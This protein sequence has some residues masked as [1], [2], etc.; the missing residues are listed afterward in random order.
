MSR[1]YPNLLTQEGICGNEE[2]PD[3]THNVTLPFTRM[4]NGAADY[5][6]CY[7]DRRLKN[8]H[9]HQL[10]AS[11]IFYS[12]LQTILWYDTPDSY[13]GEPEIKWF[14]DLESVFDDTRV[15]D[16]Y[17]GKGITMARRRGDTWW[18]A[19]MANNDGGA[20]EIPLSFLNNQKKYQAEIYTDGDGTTGTRTNVKITRQR[21]TGKDTLRFMIP[22]RGGVA[23]R[24]IPD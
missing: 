21:V 17:P 5:T 4:L 6:I 9:A 24:L 11:L 10:A 23:I 7:Y 18:V 2:F 14:E 22:A 15:L 19:S 1:T 12:P 13:G 20:V 8:T 3:A 16:G